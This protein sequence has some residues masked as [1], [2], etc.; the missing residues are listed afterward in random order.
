MRAQ[1]ARVTNSN[2]AKKLFSNLA[3]ESGIVISGLWF[4]ITDSVRAK[5]LRLLRER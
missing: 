5:D 4:K 2:L 1:P 3:A